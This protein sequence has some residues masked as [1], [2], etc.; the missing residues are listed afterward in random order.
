M[1]SLSGDRD[2]FG[3]QDHRDEHDRVHGT[4]T[5]YERGE[6]S[7]PG[8]LPTYNRDVLPVP[9]GEPS[10]FDPCSRAVRDFL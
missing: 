8:S 7:S 9:Q 6:E 3:E 4:Y 2:S 10:T 1:R 5:G